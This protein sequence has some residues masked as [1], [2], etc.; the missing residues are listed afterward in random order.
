MQDFD[1]TRNL[2]THPQL[3]ARKGT[4]IVMTAVMLVVLLGCVALAVDIGHLYVARAELQRAA[5]ASALAGAQAMGRD[6]EH[7][8]GE[9]IFANDLYSQAESYAQ[10]NDC[11]DQGVI[12]DRNADIK[13]GYLTNPRDLNATLQTLPLDQCNAIQVIAHRSASRPT[14][15]VPL[16]FARLWG[17]NSSA[18]SASA[19]A[20]LDDRFYAYRGSKGIPFT[21]HVENWYDDIIQSNGADNYG[22]DKYTG[23]VTTSPD[24]VPEVKLFP[25]K[26]QAPGNFGILHIGSGSLGVP[27]IREQIRNGISQ[28]DFVDLTGEPKVKFYGYDSGSPVSYQISGDPG[29]KAGLKDA[30]EEKIGHEVGFFLHS[31]VV[32]SGSNAVYTVVAMRFGRVMNADLSGSVRSGKAIIIQPVPHYGRGVLTSPNAPS[33]DKLIGCLELVR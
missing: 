27:T 1:Q 23:D 24:G 32:K 4:V 8:F 29:I 2:S 28:D 17:M 33:T 26:G 22:Y 7:P 3:A 12:L 6:L 30:I 10:S 19:I 25:D 18:V 9:Y 16:F 11:A 5:D 20:A 31:S 15:E 14:G 13:V 21:L